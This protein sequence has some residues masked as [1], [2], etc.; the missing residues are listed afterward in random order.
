[1]KEKTFVSADENI[2]SA[3]DHRGYHTERTPFLAQAVTATAL[4]TCAAQPP[5]GHLGLREYG[6]YVT[7]S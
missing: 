3:G 2:G 7:E 5:K 4:L 1:M 6:K